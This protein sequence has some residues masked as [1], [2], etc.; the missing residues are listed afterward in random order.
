[1]GVGLAG[2][3]NDADSGRSTSAETVKGMRPTP[4]ISI[5]AELPT[6]GSGEDHPLGGRRPADLEADGVLLLL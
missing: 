2:Q 4:A 3:A 6:P 5:V 1:M